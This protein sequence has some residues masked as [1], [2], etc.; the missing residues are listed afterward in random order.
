[1]MLS[2]RENATIR[3]SKRKGEVWTTCKRRRDRA[4]Q[5]VQR[6]ARAG[7]EPDSGQR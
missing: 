4:P 1:M 6:G 3:R 7:A 2:M 5:R